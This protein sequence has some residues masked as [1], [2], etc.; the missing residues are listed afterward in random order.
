MVGTIGFAGSRARQARTY[1]R[2]IRRVGAPHFLMSALGGAT[3]A[4]IVGLLGAVLDPYLSRYRYVVVPVLALGLAAAEVSRL[5][6][7]RVGRARQIPLSWKHEF[8]APMS[9]SLYGLTL[10]LGI[11][12][13]VY[14]WSFWAWLAL[15][16]VEGDLGLA[17]LSGLAYG[18]GRAAPVVTSSLVAS[19]TVDRATKALD[20]AAPAL[21]ILSAGGILLAGALLL[22]ESPS[23]V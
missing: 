4:L 10:G 5:E 15:L 20:G 3:L 7:Q 9:A 6:S 23:G 2:W 18:V 11:L 22:L 16:L 8:S 21:R 14:F 13:T 1:G 12:T 19:E 17:L